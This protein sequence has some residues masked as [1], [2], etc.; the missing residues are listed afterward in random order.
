MGTVDSTL[1]WATIIGLLQ[2]FWLPDVEEATESQ[3]ADWT[4]VFSSDVQFVAALNRKLSN[5][6]CI[7]HGLMWT[8]ST[9]DDTACRVESAFRVAEGLVNI[10]WAVAFLKFQKCEELWSSGLTTDD[11]SSESDLGI[12]EVGGTV[13]A[14]GIEKVKKDKKKAPP[15]KEKEPVQKKQRVTPR[16]TTPPIREMAPPVVSPAP[17]D[18]SS[19]VSPSAA[20]KKGSTLS[21]RLGLAKPR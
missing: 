7:A 4:L 15:V 8:S 19:S 1:G 10:N 11:L 20:A 3:A 16:K 2:Q 21:H 14:S 13:V 17:S 12:E 5:E 9:L 18:S 6:P